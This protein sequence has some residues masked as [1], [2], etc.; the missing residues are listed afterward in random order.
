M[1]HNATCL[2]HEVKACTNGDVPCTGNSTQCLEEV[3]CG[4]RAFNKCWG[5]KVLPNTLSLE[6][7]YTRKDC[8]KPLG[9]SCGY[10][11]D[12][13]TAPETVSRVLCGMTTMVQ[14][15]TGEK[16]IMNIVMGDMET[17]M[18]ANTLT[19]ACG[20]HGNVDQWPC[21]RA[22]TNA[23]VSLSHCTDMFTCATRNTMQCTSSVLRSV[24]TTPS[25]NKPNSPPV[26]PSSPPDD[27][28]KMGLGIYLAIAGGGV[29][30]V[31]MLAV[32]LFVRRSRNTPK[33]SGNGVTTGDDVKD[34]RQI[35][36]LLL[37]EEGNPIESPEKTEVAADEDDIALLF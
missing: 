30:L 7:L 16:D 24:S 34:D 28:V 5:K 4:M 33:F 8:A 31:A 11:T 20:M 23:D 2:Q 35:Q 25:R 19:Q 14:C 29:A 9:D 12:G 6:K 13:T 1:E 21:Y 36:L 10:N 37:G 32:V 26:V 17:C 22:L 3:Q 18:E 27:E 15:I